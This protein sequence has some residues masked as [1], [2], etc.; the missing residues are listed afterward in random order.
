VKEVFQPPPIINFYDDLDLH[1]KGEK[2]PARKT[3][4][5]GLDDKTVELDVSEEHY[6]EIYEFI[7]PLMAAGRKIG[8][9]GKVPVST[10]VIR[11]GGGEGSRKAAIDY[12]RALREWVR[13]NGLKNHAGNGWAYETETGTG[14]TYYPV[15]LIE[16]YEDYLAALAPTG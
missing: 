11:T 16:K 8:A 12:R 14:S 5:V 9:S 3:V 2:N 1:N 15:W 6:H 10:N 4:K 13:E 7:A